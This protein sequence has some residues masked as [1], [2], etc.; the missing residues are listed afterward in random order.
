MQI[1]KN[2]KNDFSYGNHEEITMCKCNIQTIFIIFSAFFLLLFFSLG[3]TMVSITKND[4]DECNNIL[5]KC[6]K[7]CPPKDTYCEGCHINTCQNKQKCDNNNCNY[8]CFNLGN[9]SS[10]Y[11]EYHTKGCLSIMSKN[12]GGEFIIIMSMVLLF[13]LLVFIFCTKEKLR[14]QR[15]Q[16]GDNSFED[17]YYPREMYTNDSYQSEN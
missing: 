4:L 15:I 13:I 7:V 8:Y 16:S 2:A 5:P 11:L 17:E 12:E 6:D 9:C 1:I 3:V 14:C 10:C